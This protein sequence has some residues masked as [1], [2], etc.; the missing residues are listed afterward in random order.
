MLRVCAGVATVVFLVPTSTLV[1]LLSC[2]QE[3]VCFY[4]PSHFNAISTLILANLVVGGGRRSCSL[5]F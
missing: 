2:V 5:I 3:A 1:I 4:V